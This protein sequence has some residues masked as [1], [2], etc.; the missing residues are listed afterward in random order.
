MNRP[1]AGPSFDIYCRVVDNF[2]DAGICWRLARQ[3]AAEQ[4]CAVRLLIDRRATLEHL[5]DHPPAPATDGF[6]GAAPAPGMVAVLDWPADEGAAAPTADVVIAAFGCRLPAGVR[7]QLRP[8]PHDPRPAPLWINYE[9]LSAEEW[10]ER[11]HGLPSIKP[12]DGAVEYFYFPGF[13]PRT[14][15]LL[16]ERDLCSERER[17]QSD[18]RPADW[19]AQRGVTRRDGEPVI[20]LFCYDD[21]WL[22]QW[23]D[24]VA[25]DAAPR[26]VVVP[27]GVAESAIGAHFGRLPPVGQSLRQG[28]LTLTRIAWLSQSDYDRLLWAS[29]LNFVRGEDSWIRAHWAARP[30][31]WQPYPQADGIHLGKLQAFLARLLARAQPGQAQVVT[32]MM[33]AWSTGVQVATAWPAFA[34]ALWPRTAAASAIAGAQAPVRASDSALAGQYREFAAALVAQP[35]LASKLLEF[36][37][38]HCDRLK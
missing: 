15:G 12:D 4:G 24:A 34:Q 3:L 38:D 27:Q 6:A 31:V 19:L 25:R 30:F 18:A 17:F 9:Y 2:G 26:T 8:D 13:T 7:R 37:R 20:S 21:P 23:F 32:G 33:S 14:G 11:A 22:A 28:A 16:R 10:V 35:D 1:P 36:A 5:L 29:D